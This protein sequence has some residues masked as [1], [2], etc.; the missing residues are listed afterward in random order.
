MSNNRIKQFNFRR[1]ILLSSEK[2]AVVASATVFLVAFLTTLIASSI[3]APIDSSNATGTTVTANINA[4][5]YYLNITSH[6]VEMNLSSSITGSYAAAYDTITTKTNSPSGYKLYVSMERDSDYDASH[7]GNA[8][9]KNGDSTV[10]PFIS[11]TNGTFSSPA[12]LDMNTWG[13]SVSNTSTG[14]ESTFFAVPLLNSPQLLQTTSSANESGVDKRLDFGFAAN[15]A[16]PMGSYAGTILYTATANANSSGNNEL[17][18]TPASTAS[19]AGG[20]S[21]VITTSLYTN[22]PLETDQV[23]VTIGGNT[24]TVTAVVTNAS[25]GTKEIT[26]TLPASA[27][28]G[29]KD[30]VVNIPLFGWNK[31]LTEGFRYGDF[32][33]ITYMQDMTTEICN[34]V[35][36]P[37]NV[38]GA[39]ASIITD[40]ANYTATADGTN[41]V[42]QRTL[43]DYRGINGTG[44]AANPAT[45]SNVA[46]YTVKKL[47]DGN[48]WMTDNLKLTLTAGQAVA[49]A[50]NS[51]GTANGTWTP[52]ASTG[53]GSA[54]EALNR[55][56]KANDATTGQWYYSWWAATAGSTE[57]TG[58]TDAQ[59]SICPVGWRL[60]SVYGTVQ[61]KSYGNLTNVYGIT[62]NG[63]SS[64][65]G[66]YTSTLESNVLNF[67]R[68]GYYPSGSLSTN[69]SSG[70]YWSSAANDAS[71]AYR[72]SYG[73]SSVLP[74]SNSTKYAGRNVRCVA[75]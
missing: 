1:K 4:S 22:Y 61:G 64:V 57:S 20:E 47:A 17:L 33:S 30:V 49:I 72:L 34:T 19:L 63:T 44:T 48:C 21:V 43:Y 41:Q 39:A 59:N 10:S 7:P 55:N 23:G 75:L 42:P 13:I 69:N 62:T 70:Y 50:K 38:V 40:K 5:D 53:D 58:G 52:V 28:A 26:C 31:T 60:P 14:K 37:S 25:V 9:Y 46:A 15:A 74:Q 71:N 45:G 18:V 56:T 65:S 66:D 36:T 54:T 12:A 29:K 51:D 73:S 8:L 67:A 11:P 3:L 35:Y 68:F 16:M 6:D 27:T 32:W 24:C 2:R